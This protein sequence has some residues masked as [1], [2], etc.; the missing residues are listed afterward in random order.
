MIKDIILNAIF[1]ACI[2]ATSVELYGCGG[3]GGSSESSSCNPRKV[4]ILDNG[5]LPEYAHLT[6]EACV[7]HTDTLDTLCYQTGEYQG[8]ASSH[9]DTHDLTCV[10][11]TALAKHANM[12]MEE[13]H[14][15]CTEVVSV[16]VFVRNKDGVP[17]FSPE[18]VTTVANW[19]G[20]QGYDAVSISW[21]WPPAARGWACSNQEFHLAIDE[22]VSRGT[23]VYA[24]HIHND[25]TLSFPWSCIDNPGLVTIA[26]RMGTDADFAVDG[27]DVSRSVVEAMILGL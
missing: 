2:I 20:T 17:V 13:L 22:L 7:Q 4:A 10:H 26:D 12:I 19:L 25:G 27:P 11:G 5:I 21:G 14:E 16:Q 9:C 1:W 18:S 23:S 3:G 15:Q 24:E 6:G 8:A